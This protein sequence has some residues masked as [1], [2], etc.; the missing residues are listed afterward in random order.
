MKLYKYAL[1]LMSTAI[2]C[3]PVA[4]EK[5]RNHGE[6]A[7]GLAKENKLEEALAEYTKAIETNANLSEAYYGRGGVYLEQEKLEEAA[8]DFRKAIDINPKYIDAHKKLA[9]TFTKIGAP[10][11]EF[12]KRFKAIENDPDNPLSYVDLGVFLHKLQ[13]ELYDI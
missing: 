5:G 4:C 6:I 3:L 9:E 12:Q 7:D 11:D 10:D 1:F 2:F 8:T 13:K